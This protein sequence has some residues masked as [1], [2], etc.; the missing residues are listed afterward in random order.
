MT[1]ADLSAL[2]AGSLPQI[3]EFHAS[4]GF[5]GFPTRDEMPA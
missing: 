1:A 2:G 4:Y 3:V 5:T